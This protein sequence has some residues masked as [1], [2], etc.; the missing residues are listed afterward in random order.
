[1]SKG[2]QVE[3]ATVPPSGSGKEGH[4]RGVKDV[5][6]SACWKSSAHGDLSPNLERLFFRVTVVVGGS[7]LVR[8]IHPGVLTVL[9]ARINA[10]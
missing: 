9:L 7:E 5:A 10:S 2:V 1:M 6:R 8:R 4:T 3:L